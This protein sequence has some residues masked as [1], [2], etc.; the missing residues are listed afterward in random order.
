METSEGATMSNVT[1]IKPPKCEFPAIGDIRNTVMRAKQILSAVIVA[2]DH[3]AS[4]NYPYALEQI[5]AMLE[6]VQESLGVLQDDED[7]KR[8]AVRRLR[9]C[10]LDAKRNRG[11]RG[12]PE[13]VS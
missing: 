11:G 2:E 4:G 13:D 7:R 10:L 9:K 1:P 6:E 3:E 5:E 8:P 12:T